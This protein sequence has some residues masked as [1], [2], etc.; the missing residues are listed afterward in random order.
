MLVKIDVHFIKGTLQ[1]SLQDEDDKEILAEKINKVEIYN[2]CGW[3]FCDSK[4][5]K[6]Y[7]KEFH[8]LTWNVDEILEAI[9]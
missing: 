7:L 3:V 9:I 8:D 5:I 2:S 1:I 6:K 4:D